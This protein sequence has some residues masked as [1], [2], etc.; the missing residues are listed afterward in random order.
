MDFIPTI[1]PEA[2]VL[3]AA[4][5]TDPNATTA[6]HHKSHLRKLT[7]DLYGP[8]VSNER[9]DQHGESLLAMNRDTST[10]LAELAGKLQAYLARITRNP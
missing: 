10:D 5:Q 1:C 2:L 9:A 3:K 8:D 6:Q 4:G 7:I